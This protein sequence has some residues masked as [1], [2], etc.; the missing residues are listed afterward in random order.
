MPP[1]VGM[2]QLGGTC[3][4][5]PERCRDR[6]GVELTMCTRW[7]MH[8]QSPSQAR[9]SAS[10]ITP[11]V[12][13]NTGVAELQGRPVTEQPPSRSTSTCRQP[14]QLQRLKVRR[15]G[16]PGQHQI[17]P[18]MPQRRKERQHLHRSQVSGSKSS[19]CWAQL[20]RRA[21]NVGVF[22]ASGST[23]SCAWFR[24]FQCLV[25]VPCHC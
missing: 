12:S 24:T 3:H 6:S 25:S 20:F 17:N 5:R 4:M 9:W 15:E 2:P 23:T 10:G 22:A 19:G 14:S 16:R 21:A 7:A 1:A 13:T 11:C 18:A 8:R